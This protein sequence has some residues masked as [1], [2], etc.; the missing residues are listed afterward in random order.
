M[1]LRRSNSI[2]QRLLQT[3]SSSERIRPQAYLHCFCR[4]NRLSVSIRSLSLLRF[5]IYI[6]SL[7][8]RKLRRMIIM[9]V[10][11]ESI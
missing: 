10:F 1:S 4:P 3:V 11:Q 2:S 9:P 6:P 5:R 7:N 8:W